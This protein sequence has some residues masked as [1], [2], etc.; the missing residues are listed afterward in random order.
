MLEG[1]EEEVMLGDGNGS[2]HA[3][4]RKSVERM[5][6]LEIE[7]EADMFCRMVLRRL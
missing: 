7:K 2:V 3:Q 1:D 4:Y 6:E 5:M